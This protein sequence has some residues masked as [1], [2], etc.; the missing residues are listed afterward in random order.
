MH[1]LKALTEND[2]KDLTEKLARGSVDG[3]DY[4]G[5]VDGSKKPSAGNEN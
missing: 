4:D 5:E 3:E 1:R 2:I